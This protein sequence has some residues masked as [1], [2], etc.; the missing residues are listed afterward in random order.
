[1]KF[2]MPSMI[3]PTYQT[4][5]LKGHL[6]GQQRPQ[7]RAD[8]VGDDLGRLGLLL[9]L[10]RR[11]DRVDQAAEHVGHGQRPLGDADVAVGALEREEECS[12]GPSH[13]VPLVSASTNLF[14]S[15]QKRLAERCARYPVLPPGHCPM[16][17][18]KRMCIERRIRGAAGAVDG[19]KRFELPLIPI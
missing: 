17:Y 12:R 8:V 3:S 13:S 2:N 4:D 6:L 5:P 7:R 9:R 10:V 11:A 1:M 15:V 18:E 19:V 16:L 14:R